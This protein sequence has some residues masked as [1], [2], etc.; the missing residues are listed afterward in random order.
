MLD[1]KSRTP[2]SL[3]A[4]FALALR[5]VSHGKL[6]M[7]FDAILVAL[8]RKGW[9]TVLHARGAAASANARAVRLHALPVHLDQALAQCDLVLCQGLATVSAALLAGRPIVQLPGHLEQA[10]ILHRVVCQGLGVGVL[11]DAGLEAISVALDL[12]HDDAGY[13]RRAASFSRHYHGFTSTL[14][15]ESVAEQC[16]ALL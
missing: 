1:Q 6:A 11:R 14:A 2:E 16:A 15:A 7:A 9:P 12:V 13:A 10:M 4:T 8:E 5:T 3:A